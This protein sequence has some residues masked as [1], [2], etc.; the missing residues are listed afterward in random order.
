M[1]VVGRSAATDNKRG[2]RPTVQSPGH[3]LIE[4]RLSSQK[5]EH[6]PHQE[7]ADRDFL[8]SPAGNWK[9]EE[10]RRTA[11][12]FVSTPQPQKDL[13]LFHATSF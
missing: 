12:N 2:R 8:L 4:L 10:A 13:L 3:C 5:R 11:D 6:V 1:C 9:T 7:L